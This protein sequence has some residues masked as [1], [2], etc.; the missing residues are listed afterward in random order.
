MPH[1]N[2]I[3]TYDKVNEN[4]QK[5]RIDYQ[6]KNRFLG[7]FA[8]GGEAII[9]NDVA[10]ELLIPSK[11]SVNISALHRM[12]MDKCRRSRVRCPMRH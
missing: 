8:T 12:T 9:V 3:Y 6:G 10:R 1:L 11:D 5:V 7:T 2:Y 4:M